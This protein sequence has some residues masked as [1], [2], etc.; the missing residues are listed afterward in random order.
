MTAPTPGSNPQSA[1]AGLPEHVKAA[2]LLRNRAVAA[3]QE[4]RGGEAE[5]LLKEAVRIFPGFAEAEIRIGNIRRAGSDLEG[6]ALAYRRALKIKPD[7]A[8]AHLELAIC[9]QRAGESDAAMDHYRRAVR[10][11]P[12]LY[13]TVLFAMVDQPQGSFWLDI[14]AL[15]RELR[16]E[17]PPPGPEKDSA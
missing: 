9:L 14:D 3:L 17:T 1:G 12:K 6:A 13:K 15:K 4:G 5:A 7:Y 11:N 8:W 16:I 10:Y 2:A